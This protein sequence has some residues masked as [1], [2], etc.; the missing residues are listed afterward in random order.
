RLPRRLVGRVALLAEG[1]DRQ[2]E[3]RRDVLRRVFLDDLEKDRREAERRVHEL[4]LRRRKGRDREVA[5]VDEAVGIREEETLGHELSI[6]GQARWSL[7]CATNAASA[8]RTASARKSCGG[9]PNGRPAVS[10]AA[11][12]VPAV[13]A[14]SARATC[15]GA[16]EAPDVTRP[17]VSKLAP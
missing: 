6:A 12:C 14:A 1:R 11:G 7:R 8:H 9:G 16:A 3:A 17:V 15:V 13:D 2:V 4:A 10:D 5:A